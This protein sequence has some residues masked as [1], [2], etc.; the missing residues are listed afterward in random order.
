M[1][2]SRECFCYPVDACLVYQLI[3]Q[4]FLGLV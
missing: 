4:F 3:Q 2:Y 1:A